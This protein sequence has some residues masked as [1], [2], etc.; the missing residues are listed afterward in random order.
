MLDLSAID[1]TILLIGHSDIGLKHRLTLGSS[2][3]NL[4]RRAGES[5]LRNY[6]KNR[7]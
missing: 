5:A 6:A 3:V 4:S 1:T 7:K 2:G